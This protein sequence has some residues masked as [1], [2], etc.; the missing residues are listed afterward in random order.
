MHG[1][2]P[3][4]GCTGSHG[5]TTRH[6]NRFSGRT[7]PPTGSRPLHQGH[8]PCSRHDSARQARLIT[9]HPLT[10]SGRVPSFQAGPIAPALTRM[11]RTVTPHSRPPSDPVGPSAWFGRARTHLGLACHSGPNASRERGPAT[12][13]ANCR[14]AAAA[15]SRCMCVPPGCHINGAG[16]RTK[17]GS[18]SCSASP[19]SARPPVTRQ[20]PRASCHL[21]FVALHS[22]VSTQINRLLS[23]PRA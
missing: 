22:T 11:A 21:A 4:P 3:R 7:Q 2:L 16:C 1:S 17:T 20:A 13:K 19:S 9:A 23:S 15:P 18:M 10:S 8:A 14:R 6:G 12:H 5:P